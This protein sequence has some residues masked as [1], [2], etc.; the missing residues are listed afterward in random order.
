MSDP[1]VTYRTRD[2]V[3][4]YRKEKDCISYLRGVIQD[5][6]L[7]TEQELDKIEETA[8]DEVK[9]AARQAIADPIADPKMLAQNIY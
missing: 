7:M 5:S 1:G 4:K 3:Q 8:D 9:E 6:K 2:E